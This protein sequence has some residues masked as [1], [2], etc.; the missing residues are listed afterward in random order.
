MGYHLKLIPPFP[1]V[2]LTR[3]LRRYFNL[4]GAPTIS[5]T[6]VTLCTAQ[7]LPKD[8]QNIPASG[9]EPF[10]GIKAHEKLT[11]G[12][13]WP[14]VDHCF[15][16]NEDPSSIPIDTRNLP[17][18]RMVETYHPQSQI[19][20]NVWGTEP[21]FQFY[22]GENTRVPAIGGLP[23]QGSRSAFCVEPS[24]YVNA[25]QE[26]AWRRMVLLKKGEKYGSRIV[27]QGWADQA[28]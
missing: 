1:S 14:V 5:G 3:R 9:P 26:E 22:T 2:S 23:A 18:Q 28:A 25:P 12:D 24:R 15:I 13:S 6:E 27:Y 16:V 11:I 19:H 10:P 8:E 7:H 17:L 21:A 4:T 20:V